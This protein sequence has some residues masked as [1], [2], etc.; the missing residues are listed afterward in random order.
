[1]ARELSP[2][3]SAQSTASV[4]KPI[5]LYRIHL[6][7]KAESEDDLF[8]AEWSDNVSFFKDVDT[9]QS[10]QAFPLSHGGLGENTRGQVDTLEITAAN[11][12]RDMQAFVES[13]DGLRGVKVTI[14][15][16]FF[17]SLSDAQAYVEDVFYID[18]AQCRTQSVVFRLTSKLDLLAVETPAR[19]FLRDHC[20][21]TFQGAGCFQDNGNGTFTTPGGFLLGSPAT[22]SKTLAEC[23]RHG[24]VP[25]FGG[26]P[27]IPRKGAIVYA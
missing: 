11:V 1:M 7:A 21:W 19:M 14:R 8:L 3:F 24:N 16:V 20:P 23:R 26:F 22:C 6:S 9:P 12:N 2:L 27:D 15:Q 25:R 10:Y 17:D 13:Y 18:S 4:N 5:W